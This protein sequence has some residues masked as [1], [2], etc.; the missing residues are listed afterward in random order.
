[1]FLQQI[2]SQCNI[3][4]GSA[5]VPQQTPPNNQHDPDY[6]NHDQ[7]LQG[8]SYDDHAQGSSHQYVNT[9]K[10]NNRRYG[11][12]EEI[13]PQPS[14][15]FS[16][17]DTSDFPDPIVQSNSELQRLNL[18]TERISS[19]VNARSEGAR[20]NDPFLYS[21]TSTSGSSPDSVL[22][23][24]AK[25]AWGVD[26]PNP[27]HTPLSMMVNEHNDLMQEQRTEPGTTEYRPLQDRT[28][29]EGN[30]VNNDKPSNEV[31]DNL[32]VTQAW[33]DENHSP[34]L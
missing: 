25:D 9:P 26:P 4:Q 17:P 10:K 23:K 6:V 18:M 14:T 2:E 8:E 1:M 3:E 34:V 16:P 29:V 21:L 31:D 27:R 28:P 19:M 24:Q 33:L 20:Y 13:D 5:P 22:D 12:Y 11:D 15:P 7:F 32:A 30:T